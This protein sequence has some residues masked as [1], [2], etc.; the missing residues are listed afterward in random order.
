M[1]YIEAQLKTSTDSVELRGTFLK[2][3]RTDLPTMIWFS[4]LVEPV[5]NHKAFFEQEGSKVLDV[6]NVWLLDYR[7]M[8]NS[9]HHE[10]FSMDVS[11]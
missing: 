11:Q 1:I 5:E 4:D 9:D 8:G 3:K 7:N 2:G 10:S 6:R